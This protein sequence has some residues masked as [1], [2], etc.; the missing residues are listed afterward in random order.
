MGAAGSTF[1]GGAN[2]EL[3]NGC[4]AGGGTVAAGLVVSCGGGTTACVVVGGFCSRVST[5]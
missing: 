5:G 4:T 1:A 3:T 2:G